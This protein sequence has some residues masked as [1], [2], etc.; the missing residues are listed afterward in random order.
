LVATSSAKLALPSPVY[1]CSASIKCV[2]H[3]NGLLVLDGRSHM[4]LLLQWSV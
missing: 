3:C 1:C 4:P 2:N